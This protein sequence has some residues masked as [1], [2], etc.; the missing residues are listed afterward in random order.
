MDELRKQHDDILNNKPDSMSDADFAEIIENHKVN[1]PICNEADTATENDPEGGDMEK[2][3]TQ[4]DVD[5]AVN[6][7]V[8]PIK[9][10]LEEIKSS[11]AEGEVDTRVAEAKA[12]GD[13]RVAAVQAQLDEAL[14][15]KG[16]AEA[17]LANVI[18][19]LEG[20][21]ELQEIAS[22]L[23]AV[24]AERRSAL[25]D[26]SNLEE[27]YIDENMDRWIAMDSETFEA[28]VEGFKSTKTVAS[29]EETVTGGENAKLDTAMNNTRNDVGAES[30]RDDMKN[31]FAARNAGY[32]VKRI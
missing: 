28:V 31:I 1:C 19:Y 10:E 17:E 20:E 22:Y 30:V 26:N 32:N 15:A 24:K 5:A 29:K 13:A 21:I 25:V 23:D 2:E 8:A 9:A 3:F 11:I 14:N 18:S 12:D 7:A 27:S 16:A 6:A 4:E